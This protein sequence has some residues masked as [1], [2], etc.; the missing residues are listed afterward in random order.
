MSMAPPTQAQTHTQTA[1]APEPCGSGRSPT[2]QEQQR[3]PGTQ[4]LQ[5]P[6]SA[7]AAPPAVRSRTD[8]ASVAVGARR[9]MPVRL[10][11]RRRPAGRR[12]ADPA[13]CA[14]GL[15]GSCRRGPART[16]TAADHLGV[17]RV[18]RARAGRVRAAGG[19]LTLT[20]V[21]RLW[22]ELVEAVK[23]RRRV[24]WIQLSQHAQVVGLDGQPADPRLQQRRCPGVVRQRPRRR[25]PP[26]VVIDVI[27]QD[28]RIDAIVDPSAQPGTEPRIS[29]T[30]PAVDE[31]SA[32]AA[33][34]GATV[35]PAE[36]RV[37]AR[38]HRAGGGRRGAAGPAAA[39]AG[40]ARGDPLGPG[41]D[42]ADPSGRD[43]ASAAA[44]TARST[45]TPTATT[46]TSTT[47][48]PAPSC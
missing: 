33:P 39:P 8:A 13:Q 35:A 26:A 1:A 6:P 2:P 15:A 19:G 9:P 30:R 46:P 27:G 31:A 10:A 16:P 11:Q 45:R 18:V 38:R 47:A 25:D 3:P 17:H 29:V 42:P 32:S 34:H 7:P 36:A 20:D 44:R 41:G 21:R 4:A 5:P 12:V 37:R 28:W 22:P 24:T 40:V 48:S 43:R 14:A 23:S